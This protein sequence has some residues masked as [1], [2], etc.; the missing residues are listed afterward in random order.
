LKE[1]LSQVSKTLNRAFNDAS[2]FA[3]ASTS[4]E[5]F[6]KNV[7]E[8]KLEK[9]VAEYVRETDTYLPG[10]NDARS[11][12]QWANTAKVGDVSEVFTVGDK[13]IIA[14][15]KDIR[16]KDKANFESAKTRVETDYRKDKK[17]EQLM[18]KAKTALEGATTLDAVSKKLN[19]PIVPTSSLNLENPFF[20][21]IGGDNSFGG[22]VFGSAA[23][24]LSGPAKGDAAVYVFMINKF[25]E[26]PAIKDYTQYKNEMDNGVRQRME[27]GYLEALK[28]IKGVKDFRF[29]FF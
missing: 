2:Q 22:T 12:V 6:D 29:K 16:E 11:V 13:Y 19:S 23:G 10:Y 7:A 4:A 27:Y 20:A 8:R 9:K 28:D 5:E 21:N 17:A 3:S 24:K 14:I 15:L 25:N 26:A 1:P 18:E